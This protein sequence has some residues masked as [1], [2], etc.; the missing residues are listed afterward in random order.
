MQE[1]DPLDDDDLANAE[2]SNRIIRERQERERAELEKQRREETMLRGRVLDWLRSGKAPLPAAY[3]GARVTVHPKG[4]RTA[5]AKLALRNR[6]DSG[7]APVW[8]PR[9]MRF[10]DGFAPACEPTTAGL[11]DAGLKLIEDHG[12]IDAVIAMC[13]P[14]T[15]SRWQRVTTGLRSG[16]GCWEVWA[17]L[18]A[19]G[20]TAIR[21]EAEYRGGCSRR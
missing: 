10:W 13:S 3:P 4:F 18:A 5:P 12:S 6:G 14:E 19:K 8:H 15:R 17:G 9:E 2:E 11:R 7:E 21:S 16:D 1:F 20:L